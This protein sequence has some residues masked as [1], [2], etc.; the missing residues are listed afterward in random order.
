MPRDGGVAGAV[1]TRA[2]SR[3]GGAAARPP[4]VGL[5]IDRTVVIPATPAGAAAAMAVGENNKHGMIESH[6]D[7]WPV[8]ALEATLGIAAQPAGL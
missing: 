7:P 3:P 5:V 8:R 4:A 6:L 2:A 1:G